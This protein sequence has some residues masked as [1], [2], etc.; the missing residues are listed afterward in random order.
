MNFRRRFMRGQKLPKSGDPMPPGWDKV[1]GDERARTNAVMKQV[2]AQLPERGLILLSAPAGADVQDVSAIACATNMPREQASMILTSMLEWWEP[3][4]VNVQP[5]RHVLEALRGGVAMLRDVDLGSILQA[6]PG[7]VKAVVDGLVKARASSPADAPAGD[8]AVQE[9]INA[10]LKLGVEAMSVIDRILS[11]AP[12]RD[13][14]DAPPSMFPE[15]DPMPPPR[16]WPKGD[17]KTTLVE[18]LL[19]KPQSQWRD[20][21]IEMAKRGAY[22]DFDS[23]AEA[24]KAI[25]VE[26]LQR[27]GFA[28]LAG[29]ARDGGYDDEKPTTEQIEE[30]RAQLGPEL[31]DK[32]MSNKR[33]D[34]Q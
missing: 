14:A 34:V 5:D 2:A 21:I 20:Q 9:V 4:G 33:R 25:L 15:P 29:K 7:S 16:D 26:T 18:D 24:P 19:A 31:F 22:H 27:F 3:T 13:T 23:E 1:Q 28:D 32:M 6:L 17:T 12:P 8:A 10:A 30:M 11:P